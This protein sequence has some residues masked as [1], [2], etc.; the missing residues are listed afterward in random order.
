MQISA[1]WLGPLKEMHNHSVTVKTSGNVHSR[2]ITQSVLS[3]V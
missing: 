1:F 2:V 3:T